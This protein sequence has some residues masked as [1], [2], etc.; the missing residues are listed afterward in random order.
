[1]NWENSKASM[2]HILKLKLTSKLDLRIG[3]KVIALSNLSIYY[4][5]KNIKSS[6]NNNKFKISAPRW[7]EEFKLPDGS[8]SV[9]DIQDYFE[10]ILKKHGENTNKP[11]IYIH[12]NK[13]ENRITF[14]IKDG[15]SLEIL[16]KETMKLLGSVENKIT[17]DKNSENVTHLEITEVVLVHCNMVTND[18][19]QDSRVLHTFVPNKP[20][21]SLLDISSANHIFLKTFNSEYNEIEVWFIDQNSKPLE[22]ENRINLTMVKMRYSIEARDRIYVK[23]YGFSF[24][25]KN[26]GRNL[27]NKYGQKIIDTTKKS[28]ADSIKTT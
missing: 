4:T 10:Y 19:Q 8:Y 7:N 6:Y 13:I 14:K 3:E 17:K 18:Y 12:V 5:W 15:C 9:S 26:I 2:P 28:A 20:F 25:A 1:M 27:S 22:I 11:S 21:G 23:R 24:F 16:T